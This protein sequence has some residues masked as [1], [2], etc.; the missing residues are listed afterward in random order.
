MGI[1]F[2]IWE[3]SLTQSFLYIN[4]RSNLKSDWLDYKEI[5]KTEYKDSV[6][7]PINKYFY[8]L[9]TPPKL[10]SIIN[11]EITLCQE[12][13]AEIFLLKKYNI[14]NLTAMEKIHMRQF[15]LSNQK[16]ADNSLCF[17]EKFRWAM[18]WFIDYPGI[19]V[20]ILPVENSPFCFEKYSYYFQAKTIDRID[21]EM[22]FFKFKNQ[23]EHMVDKEYGR[24]KRNNPAYLINFTGDDILVK[25]IK[26]FY[27]QH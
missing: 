7:K 18:Q 4:E 1:N 14:E 2:Y 3:K 17:D 26:E 11:N 12:N 6:I 10:V 23:G 25:K 21:P 15:Y 9:S 5:L 20:N 24:I 22:L 13:F 8:K 16:T 19:K 27:G